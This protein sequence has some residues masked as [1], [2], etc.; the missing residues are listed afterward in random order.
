MTRCNRRP[1]RSSLALTTGPPR[2]AA[3]ARQRG[4][5]RLSLRHIITSEVRVQADGAAVL[6][7]LCWRWRP[8]RPDRAA[9][10]RSP[11]SPGVDALPRRRGRHH[12]ARRRGDRLRLAAA[13]GADRHVR[14]APQRARTTWSRRSSGRMAR[15]EAATAS[16]NVRARA[17]DGAALGARRRAPRRDRARRRVRC[18]CSDSAAASAR[19]PAASRPRCSSSTA[20]TRSI[21]GPPRRAA[22][23]SCSTCPTRSYGETVQY[24]IAGPMRAA[25]AGAVALLLRVGGPDRPA[26]APHRRARATP[27]AVAADSGGGD[28]GRGCRRCSRVCSDRGTPVRLRLKMEARI[29]LPTRSS[30]NVVGRDARTRA[31]RR[32]RRRRR[33]FRFVGRRH[34]RERRWR[35]AASSRGRRCG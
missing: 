24:R 3:S 30:A 12:R 1:A 20:S 9:T 15:L 2:C 25:R 33:A 22:A 31:A 6:V 13:R 32:D 21:G 5:G 26:H 35:S 10:T 19:R 28:L 27:T 14:P 17:G 11:A 8:R 29:E 7:A 4:P 18:R 23:S 34:G 16:T